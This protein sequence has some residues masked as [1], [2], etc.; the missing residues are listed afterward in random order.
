[1]LSQVP[2]RPGADTVRITPHTP[3]LWKRGVLPG[4]RLRVSGEGTLLAGYRATRRP[5]PWGLSGQRAHPADEKPP[6]R[7]LARSRAPPADSSAGFQGALLWLSV[8]T[9]KA[10]FSF[11]TLKRNHSFE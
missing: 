7:R 4:A 11:Q 6:P 3:E 8:R 10:C 5:G 9:S 1:M 2:G